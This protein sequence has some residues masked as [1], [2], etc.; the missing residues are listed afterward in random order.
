MGIIVASL[1]PGLSTDAA[2]SGVRDWRPGTV[3]T[4]SLDGVV[5][6]FSLDAAAGL[7][8]VKLT[9]RKLLAVGSTDIGNLPGNGLYRDQALWRLPG[10]IMVNHLKN[11]KDGKPIFERVFVRA[12]GANLP[13][14]GDEVEWRDDTRFGPTATGNYGN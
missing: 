4:G 3:L 2:L 6:S 7:A 1:G 13:N 5:E 14:P 10:G 9:V 12:T 11:I 8:G